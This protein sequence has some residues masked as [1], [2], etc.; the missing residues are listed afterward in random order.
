MVTQSLKTE[1][2]F[3]VEPMGA[4]RMTQSDRWKR[5]EAQRPEVG[6]YFAYKQEL[7]LKANLQ[8][9]RIGSRISVDFYIPMPKSW[10]KKERDK[11]RGKP[12]K[13]K[14]DTDNLIKAFKDALTTD[15]ARIWD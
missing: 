5:D 4:V 15:D 13:A 10:S 7:T 6:R 3:N 11:M 12:C 2:I 14:P 9:Y 1:Y 8:R